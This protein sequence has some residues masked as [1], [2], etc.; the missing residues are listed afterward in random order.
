MSRI[1][2]SMIT[3]AVENV[4]AN[5]EE[6]KRNFKQTIEIQIGLKGYGKKDKRF[7]SVVEVPHATRK[8]TKFCVLGDASHIQQAEQLGYEL[9]SVDDLKGLNKEKKLV[10]KLAKSYHFFLASPTVARTLNRLVG[11]TFN[12]L[13][14]FPTP[15]LKGESLEKKAESGCCTIRFKLQKAFAFNYAIGHEEMPIEEIVRNIATSLGFLISLLKKGMQNLG[16]VHVKGTMCSPVR[17]Y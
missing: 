13:G 3:D 9:R 8:V 1:G 14:K 12:K 11:N 15:V 10:K 2:I 17:L 5:I 6:S 4:F 16:S 7:N